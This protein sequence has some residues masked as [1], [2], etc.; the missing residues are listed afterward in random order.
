ME[1][2]VEKQ[3]HL[4]DLKIPLGSLLSFYG[5]VLILYGIFSPTETYNRS[6]HIDINLVWGI[7]VLIVGCLF[8]SA[9]Y[10]GRRRTHINKSQPQNSVTV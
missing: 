3:R 4:F 6:L 8:L 2:V 1:S 10:F 5:I 7:L 9:A